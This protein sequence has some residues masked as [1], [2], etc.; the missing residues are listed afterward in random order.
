M[1]PVELFIWYYRILYK[2]LL[3]TLPNRE[4]PGPDSIFALL[5]YNNAV[6]CLRLLVAMTR[7]SQ[8]QRYIKSTNTS[9]STSA[10]APINAWQTV[11]VVQLKSTYHSAD[12]VNQAQTTWKPT[13]NSLKSR[14]QSLTISSQCC[15]CVLLDPDTQSAPSPRYIYRKNNQNNSFS[16]AVHR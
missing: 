16:R 1:H 10:L 3:G 2:Q 6:R 11:V 14:C 13:L 9:A 15:C 12:A 8:T 5:W 7:T 4:R